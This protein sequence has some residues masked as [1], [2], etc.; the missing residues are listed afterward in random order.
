MNSA[1]IATDPGSQTKFGT[2]WLGG[3]ETL[4]DWHTASSMRSARP[5][6][7]SRL[8]DGR[9]PIRYL[10]TD[11]DGAVGQDTIDYLTGC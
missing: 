7:A 4:G 1:M 6:D 2:H 3:S 10:P 8:G 9:C 11:R 5:T